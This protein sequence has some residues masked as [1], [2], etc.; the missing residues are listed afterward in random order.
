MN[1]YSL[2]TGTAWSIKNI[3]NSTITIKDDEFARNLI[4][5][6]LSSNLI[7]VFFLSLLLFLY[8]LIFDTNITENKM[9]SVD[10][11]LVSAIEIQLDTLYIL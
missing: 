4:L 1:R 7:I 11:N 9:K 6:D 3:D 5:F 2:F 8:V 10:V